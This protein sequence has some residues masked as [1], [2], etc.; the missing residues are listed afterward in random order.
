M[1][2]LTNFARCRASVGVAAAVTAALF[3][4]ACGQAPQAPE[5]SAKPEAHP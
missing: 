4:T 3:L 1:R 5:V 2:T